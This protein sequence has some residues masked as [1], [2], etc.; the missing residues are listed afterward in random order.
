MKDFTLIFIFLCFAIQIIFWIVTAFSTKQ[1]SENRGG[2]TMRISALII[3]GSVIFLK[4]QIA[5]IVPFLGINFWPR[6]FTTGIVADAATFLGM[7]IMIWARITLGKN[8]SANVVFK[9]NHELITHGP[10]SYARHPIYSGLLLMV[11]GVA[12]YSGSSIWFL[13]F[14]LFF[15]GAYYKAYKE[16]KLLIKYFPEEYPAYARRVRA[17]IPFVL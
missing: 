15:L 17:I 14:V 12:I 11:L 2:W 6:S 8:W 13:F 10:Y 9:E 1:A 7:A 3:V 16:E 4:D 5:T